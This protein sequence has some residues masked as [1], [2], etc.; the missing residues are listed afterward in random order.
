MGITEISVN[1]NMTLK[2]VYEKISE[3]V[4]G[5]KVSGVYVGLSMILCS[6]ILSYWRKGIILRTLFA[7]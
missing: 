2:A 4:D 6:I 3:V 1:G 5:C 7:H